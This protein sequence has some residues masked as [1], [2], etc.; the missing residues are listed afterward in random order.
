MASL[1]R[2]QMP[3]STFGPG[4]QADS[5]NMLMMA[6]KMAKQAYMGLPPGTKDHKRLGQA[7]NHLDALVPQMS[8]QMPGVGI[9]GTLLTQLFRNLGSSPILQSLG[10]GMGGGAGGGGGQQVAQA[11]P[12]STPFPGA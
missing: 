4:R 2:P 6:I 9:Q 11:Q 1:G 5:V 8:G 10:G 7:I 12:P 3:P